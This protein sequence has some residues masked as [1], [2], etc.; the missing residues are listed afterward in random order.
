AGGA[1]HLV[2]ARPCQA[3]ARRDLRTLNDLHWRS[4]PPEVVATTRATA[5]RH[6][7]SSRA[8]NRRTTD[9]D[10]LAEGRLLALNEICVGY[11][12]QPACGANSAS[13]TSIASPVEDLRTI[14]AGSL[15]GAFDPR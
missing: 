9:D 8:R 12:S 10:C 5:P 2:S 6:S 14:T 7:G 1:R 4:D 15:F 3:I 13:C 11:R